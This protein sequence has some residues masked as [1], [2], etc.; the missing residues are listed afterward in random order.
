MKEEESRN[1]SSP[2][3]PPEDTGTEDNIQLGGEKE[4]FCA[5][6]P[7]FQNETCCYNMDSAG[8]LLIHQKLQLTQLLQL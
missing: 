2:P 1:L 3:P 6:I 7:T 5:E 4:N 8:L